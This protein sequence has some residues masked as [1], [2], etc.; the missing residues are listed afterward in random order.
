MK[1]GAQ[2]DNLNP[3]SKNGDAEPLNERYVSAS[4]ISS[5]L[6]SLKSQV[7]REQ[8][9]QKQLELIATMIHIGIPMLALVLNERRK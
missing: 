5:K 7:A 6:A 8:D 9:I 4:I 3:Y 2:T 1:Q